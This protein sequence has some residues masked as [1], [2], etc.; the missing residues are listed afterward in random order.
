MLKVIGNV[1]VKAVTAPFA[2]L[3]GG[4]AEDLSRVAFEPGTATLRADSLAALDKVARALQD[5]PALNVT[6]TGQVHDGAERAAWQAA[7]LE[8]RLQTLWQREL[9]RPARAPI[10]PTRPPAR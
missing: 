5:R 3:A 7:A 9:A 1:L 6:I 4:G 8:R 10:W 2:L